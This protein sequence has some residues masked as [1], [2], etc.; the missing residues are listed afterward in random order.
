MCSVCVSVL[1][2]L[3]EQFFPQTIIINLTNF[4]RPLGATELQICTVLVNFEDSLLIAD[5][6]F[7]LRRRTQ[8]EKAIHLK[9][10]ETK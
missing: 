8:K 6:N 3:I 1:G 10:S 4:G 2:N 5:L 9:E 7:P